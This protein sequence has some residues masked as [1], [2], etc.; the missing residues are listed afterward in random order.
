[1]GDGVPDLYYTHHPREG[2]AEMTAVTGVPRRTTAWR[3]GENDR[4]RLPRMNALPVDMDRDG[5]ADP[6]VD[7]MDKVLALSGRDGRPL[8]EVPIG[9]RTG[10]WSIRPPVDLDGDGIPDGVV[11]GD[12]FVSGPVVAGGLVAG[13]DVEDVQVFSGKTGRRLFSA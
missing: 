11:V 8:W 5:I 9:A 4:L 10:F 13:R 7:S 12:T 6:V 1:N 2:G 3:G